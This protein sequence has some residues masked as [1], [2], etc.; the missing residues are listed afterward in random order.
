MFGFSVFVF[1]FRLEC[2]GIRKCVL[3]K[4]KTLKVKL[5]L[6]FSDLKSESL[7]I[8]RM[9]SDSDMFIMRDRV[10]RFAA[11]FSFG[12]E[13]RSLSAISPLEFGKTAIR[14]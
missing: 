11:C 1:S 8:V 13:K 9:S 2:F 4:F 6:K 3:F 14:N 5:S 10:S 12:N 7:F